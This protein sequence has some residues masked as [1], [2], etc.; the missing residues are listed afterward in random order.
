MSMTEYVY[1]CTRCLEHVTLALPTDGVQRWR[2]EGMLIQ[3]ALPDT[4][5]LHREMFKMGWC[6]PCVT[7]VYTAIETEEP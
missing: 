5:P 2:E 4:P 6:E 7:E 3:R 1:K